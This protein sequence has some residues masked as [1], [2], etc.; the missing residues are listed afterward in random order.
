MHGLA[1]TFWVLL[2]INMIHHKLLRSLKR[3]GLFIVFKNV[4]TNAGAN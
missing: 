2:K 4:S 3:L 1:L